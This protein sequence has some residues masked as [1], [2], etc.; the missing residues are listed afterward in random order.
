MKRNYKQIF[1]WESRERI[2]YLENINSHTVN[3][4]KN[5][6]HSSVGDSWEEDQ[7]KHSEKK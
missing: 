5:I 2:K 4:F 1:S 6:G 7:P 3:Y